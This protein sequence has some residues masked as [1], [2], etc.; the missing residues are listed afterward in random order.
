M[1]CSWRRRDSREANQKNIVSAIHVKKC[2]G[3][4]KNGVCNDTS[5]IYAPLYVHSKAEGTSIQNE[6]ANERQYD[7]SVQEAGRKVT[8]T[9]VRSFVWEG[10]YM[11]LNAY[12]QRVTRHGKSQLDCVMM[13]D[14]V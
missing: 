2:G 14:L 10:R 5:D 1:P 7:A 8:Q 9:V 13:L 12:P 4:Q 11:E 6:L 3:L